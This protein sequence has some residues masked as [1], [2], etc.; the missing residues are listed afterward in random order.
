MAVCDVEEVEGGSRASP[1]G[2][3][4]GSTQQPGPSSSTAMVDSTGMAP[5]TP[6]SPPPASAPCGDNNNQPV[7]TH[8]STGSEGSASE[9]SAQPSGAH[10][11]AT[12][13]EEDG[14]EEAGSSKRDSLAS[15]EKSPGQRPP[16]LGRQTRSTSVGEQKWRNVR[17]VMALYTRLRKIKRTKSNQRW[18]KLRTTVQLSGA[19]SSTIQKKPPLKREDSFLKR[20]STRQIPETQET[21]DT[22]DDGEG[23]SN[24]QSTNS[25]R[26]RRR[27]RQQRLPRTVVNPDENF[28]FYWL[29]VLTVC[30]LYNLWT[31]IVRQSFPELQNDAKVFW[32]A[33]DSFSDAV[34]LFDVAVQFRTGY[35]EQGLMV[36][37]SKK[38]AGHYLRSR[39]FLLDLSALLPLDLL[40]LNFGPI[41][42]LRFPRFLKLYRVYDYYYMVESRTVYPNLWRVVNLIHILLI[43][44]HWFGC[45]YYL[46]SEAEN[47]QG[48]WVYPYRPGDYATLT[49]KYLGSLYWSTLTLTT[50]GDLPTPETNADS[51]TRASTRT[52][53]S[54]A[55]TSRNPSVSTDGPQVLPRRGL[56]SR[57]LQF[58]SNRGYVFT[59][60]SY[61]IGVFIFATIV[62]QVGNVITNRNANRL[63]FERLLDGAKTYMRHHKVPGGMKRRVLRWYDYSWSRGRIQGG[64]DI[65]TALGL[66][67]DK[68]K[69]ELALH[70]NLSVL[71]K[72]TIFQECQ[73][74]FLHDLVLKM[75]AYIFTPG[76]LIC[77]KGEVAR[78]M[79]IIADGILEVISETGRVLTTMKAGDFFGEI[80]I[81]NLDG[82][83][84]RTADVRS[85]GYSELFSLSRED[86]LAAMKDYPE[87]QEIL[88]SLGR[89]R[90]MEARN[91][92]KPKSSGQAGDGKGGGG[93]G[94]KDG[95]AGADGDSRAG[96]R[97]VEKLR[98]DVKG[99]K[100]VL[101][102]S[103]RGARTKDE[104]LELQ[105]LTPGAVGS[106]GEGSG[107]VY[108][109]GK[110]M[111][112]RMSRVR[113][114]ETEEPSGSSEQPVSP[115]EKLGA[116]L[117]LLHRLRLL[118]EKQ[119][120]EEKGKALL[121]P[122]SSTPPAGSLSPPSSATIKA[123]PAQEQEVIGAGL[124][125]IQRLM[126]LKQKEEK[127][128][129]TA[130]QATASGA[131]EVL[132]SAVKSSEPS[133]SRSKES[134]LSPPT[135]GDESRHSSSKE[136]SEDESSSSKRSSS[137]LN[138]LVSLKH[139]ESVS[140][141]SKPST[142]AVP[143]PSTSAVASSEGSGSEQA[144]S[145]VTTT[146]TTLTTTTAKT[147]TTPLLKDKIK[148]LV[149]KDTSS[150]TTT[151]ATTTTT[152]ST[153]GS[154]LQVT[155]V[156][157]TSGTSHSGAGPPPMKKQQS[158][159]LLKKA[160]IVSST[161]PKVIPS[162]VSKTLISPCVATKIPPL[163]GIIS[164]DQGKAKL[165]TNVCEPSSPLQSEIP[166][167]SRF[168]DSTN[169]SETTQSGPSK[170]VVIP[171]LRFGD[172]SVSSSKVNTSEVSN[173]VQGSI[174]Q[175][176][177]KTSSDDNKTTDSDVSSA[178]IV[179]DL[180]QSET[181]TVD[182]V[183]SESAAT[184]TVPGRRKPT[185]LKIQQ[186][187]KFYMSI[188]DLSPE[189][190]GLP[191]VKKLKI[192]NERQK[193][194]ELER[195]M[196][197]VFMRSSSLDSSNTATMSA[198]GV[199]S[200]SYDAGDFDPSL[201][202]S[203]SEASA[204]EYVRAQQL[205]RVSYGK[206]DWPRISQQ[207]QTQL[208]DS[209]E[210]P[211]HSPESN[212]TLE[213]RNLKSILKKLSASS[214]L[215]GST[216]DAS[217]GDGT[218]SSDTSSAPKPSKIDMHKLMRAPT[219]EGY[220]A[221]HSKLTKSVT[222][223]R[224]TLQSP[225]ATTPT[226]ASLP[227][228]TFPISGG[229]LV[230]SE[231]KEITQ[232]PPDSADKTV[233][234]SDPV[235]RQP[236]SVIPPIKS[237]V[238]KPVASTISSDAGEKSAPVD[239][240]ISTVTSVAHTAVQVAL[241]DEYNTVSV[242]A[243]ST[244]VVET[245]VSTTT[246]PVDTMTST[247]AVNHSLEKKQLP[248]S[249]LVQHPQIPNNTN[250]KNFFRPS[251]LLP[252]HIGEEEY[253]SE[254]IVGIKQV[255]QNHLDDIQK[256]FHSQFES[257]EL[258]VKRRDEIISQLQRRIQELEHPREHLENGDDGD[259][260]EDLDEGSDQPF[261]RGD[262][263]DTVLTS[264]P[265]I[266]P[267]EDMEELLGNGVRHR[268]MVTSHHHRL[269]RRSWEDH[270][271]EETLELLDLPR[272]ITPQH[273]WL[274]ESSHSNGLMRQESVAVDMGSSDSESSSSSS[275][276][277]EEDHFQVSDRSEF[278]THNRDW[279]V[280]MLARELE[281]RE[282][283]TQLQDEVRELQE[284]V[285][286][287]DLTQLSSSE[288]D[289][290]ERVLVAED[291][292]VR[293]VARA[294]SLD[295]D[296]SCDDR[297]LHSKM[298][299]VS[300]RVRSPSFSFTS[301]NRRKF[302]KQRSTNGGGSIENLIHKTQLLKNRLLSAATQPQ[303][304]DAAM[305]RQ[306]FL[307][308]RS[309]S[310]HPEI[311][312]TSRQ[313]VKQGAR[314][315]SSGSLVTPV[316][317][318]S[319]STSSPSS[320]FAFAPFMRGLGQFVRHASSPRTSPLSSS[321]Q[322]N[323]QHSVSSPPRADSVEMS[324][325]VP[326]ISQSCGTSSQPTDDPPPPDL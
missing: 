70:V 276:G 74:E 195:K 288:L 25:A 159:T 107:S 281:R 112:R 132:S 177:L 32:F 121:S 36:Y 62:G 304:S 160:A 280:Q 6:S 223:N 110:G 256:K 286:A 155:S 206:D 125:L 299:D 91:M 182:S 284:A 154:G 13:R 148:I 320:S 231:E 157:S 40:Q 204:M 170:S 214:L 238:I 67:P 133:S 145:T 189:Y 156:A 273:V 185:L 71:K 249:F 31:L 103:R 292:K 7:A 268:H 119:D 218:G 111:L 153:T 47:F 143:T 163:L 94:G 220:A 303:R 130:L 258:E 106:G 86:V 257:M 10:S 115:T 44:A 104:S 313:S 267:D 244:T 144:T 45:F 252:S 172:K 96:K 61:L 246:A 85:V 291:R 277:S 17:A 4:S 23:G 88:Q 126:L 325:V 308:A 192:L 15:S 179:P 83:N 19:I 305:K 297:A 287:S 301:V 186:G 221:R 29:F 245:R 131:A 138:R 219:V 134:S 234:I 264:P 39:A 146:T 99:L 139:K 294:L 114:D 55:T 124:P 269:Q 51:Q 279:E 224:E 11:L 80:G 84:K 18:M 178:K 230:P 49:R 158:W 147:T 161:E 90:L 236:P 58:S 63:E 302:S 174:A 194:A 253:F 265:P 319:S 216:E 50:I 270:S 76:D 298:K 93:D 289:I 9:S 64:G 262:S 210:Q 272:S 42:I 240:T 79:F 35:L 59:I 38:L 120:R 232:I 41:P 213:R 164:S 226:T 322:I 283:I 98:S 95:V 188:D 198:C 101:R 274:D 295:S 151:A 113:S 191:F 323:R 12:S 100:N 255:I 122:T 271:E 316:T 46:L 296:E 162:E 167:K 28:Y 321:A 140:A 175:D 73:P 293:A 33:C 202:R 3:S 53:N 180:P 309:L 197:G 190:S 136:H 248:E 318:T 254:I 127:E 242:T 278:C 78:E 183:Q 56:K 317:K 310:E 149:Q 109:S 81:L 209:S 222:F 228:S 215:S 48:D 176:D 324:T 68:L 212:E 166:L 8:P 235:L 207:T 184:V 306:Q 263:V 137:I 239:P 173:E 181:T 200:G 24:S 233:I 251:L 169:E 315:A 30:V 326:T 54:P 75:K 128:R 217:A 26:R 21:V 69:T 259:F 108:S 300:G 105:P 52:A 227:E 1:P 117:P 266:L 311:P 20:F 199:M 314:S 261:M 65:N 187:T 150:V 243:I 171:S 118:K 237:L 87:A 193:L 241:S 168:D 203:H 211:P 102:K 290:L 89:K 22:G 285:S 2:L 66:L 201:T 142:S 196:A 208:P 135:T 27:R 152:V 141:V 92:S 5:A 129:L 312:Q 116:G 43:L 205:S 260:S 250:Q 229:V 77:R 34:F 60:V 282:G 37:D 57:L 97:I 225:P 14:D 72:V 165:T 82:L 247:T 275:A 16:Q 123:E 307:N